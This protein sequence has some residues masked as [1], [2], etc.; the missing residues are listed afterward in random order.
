M[1][2]TKVM[3]YEIVKPLTCTWDVFG[4]ILREVRYESFRIKN[5]TIQQY[6][7]YEND[8]QAYKSLHGTYPNDLDIYGAKFATYV[9][10][11]IAHEFPVTI[12]TNLT[13]VIQKTTKSW[14]NVKNDVLRGRQSIPSFRLN[15]PIEINATNLRNFAKQKN[16]KVELDVALVSNVGVEY[17]RESLSL[18]SNQLETIGTTYRILIDPGQG[19]AKAILNRIVAGEYNLGGSMIVYHERKKK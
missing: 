17:L 4:T 19:A 7:Q 15:N 14:K 3:Q 12:T 10:R 11:V 2:V 6:Y 5:R 18:D 9:Y 1:V 13:S 16:G 8:R